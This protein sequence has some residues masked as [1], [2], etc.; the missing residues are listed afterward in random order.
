MERHSFIFLRSIFHSECSGCWG[1]C[2]DHLFSVSR[3]SLAVLSKSQ[4]SFRTC[5]RSLWRA[6]I[7]VRL[8][9]CKVM[10][11]FM[12]RY[13]LPS[14]RPGHYFK[15]SLSNHCL[16]QRNVFSSLLKIR[17]WI[18]TG[19]NAFRFNHVLP[20]LWEMLLYKTKKPKVCIETW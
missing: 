16:H 19:I 10:N 18:G 1:H 4:P 8:N 3:L 7:T 17:E 9:F 14:A 12:L 11:T 2:R 15:E 5:H 20:G 13:W 6:G